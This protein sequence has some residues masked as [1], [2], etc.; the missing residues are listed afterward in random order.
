MR[1]PAHHPQNSQHDLKAEDSWISA[2][3][4]A[5]VHRADFLLYFLLEKDFFF[6]CLT[7]VC[8]ENAEIKS[9]DGR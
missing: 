9:R 2:L 6:V 1:D 7:V 8:F 4:T 5:L 3:E